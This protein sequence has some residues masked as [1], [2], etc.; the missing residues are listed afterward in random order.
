MADNK[1]VYLTAEGKARLEEKLQHLLTVRR[2]EV[3]DRIH[4]AKADGDIS[5]SGEYED[6]KNEQAWLEGEIRS[7]EHTLRYAQLIANDGAN[8]MVALGSVI[9]VKDGDG[10]EETYTLVGSA[11]ANSRQ[12]K[13]SNESPVGKALLGHKV[14][15]SVTVHSP[16]GALEF[17]ILSIE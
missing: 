3:A 8:G 2:P 5:E 17:T 4:Q 9:K 1:P 14:G 13:I 6:A 10:E 16:A 15:D 11:E 12:R 7:L